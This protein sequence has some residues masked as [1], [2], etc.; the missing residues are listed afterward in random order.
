MTAG[1]D[2][3]PNAHAVDHPGGGSAAT[4]ASSSSADDESS[5]PS[6]L[7]DHAA[8]MPPD[9]GSLSDEE[10]LKRALDAAR[11]RDLV[12]DRLETLAASDDD[13][14]DAADRELDRIVDDDASRAIV[15]G[16][17]APGAVD[18]AAAT[19]FGGWIPCDA[20]ADRTLLVDNYDSYTY[21]LY[22][23]IAAVD[24]APPVVVRNDA[25]AWR[26]LAPS[27]RA[28]HF[29]RVVL[30]PGPGTPDRSEDV[31]IC[32]D[33]LS[34]AVDVPVLGVCLGH[35]ALAAAHGG[36]VGRAPVPM[37]GRLHV[38]VHDDSPLF[39]GIPSGGEAGWTGGAEGVPRGVPT[40][41]TGKADRSW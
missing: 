35:Q 22:H 23:L 1:R 41:T 19:A 12:R 8:A 3:T 5:A 26:Q 36:V 10:W 31:G 27:L 4:L 6:P 29:A 34:N 17:D 21:N 32:A 2:T 24:G 33:V 37:H 9:D 38:V 39:A 13:G 20:D 14:G 15:R 11:E 30:S 25:I 16:G 18:R 40:T 28:G 7:M